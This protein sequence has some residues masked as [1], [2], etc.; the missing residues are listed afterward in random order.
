MSAQLTGPGA[1]PRKSE[2]TLNKIKQRLSAIGLL[3]V[4][5]SFPPVASFAFHQTKLQGKKAIKTHLGYRI[6]VSDNVVEESW[7]ESWAYIIIEQCD[8]EPPVMIRDEG[9]LVTASDKKSRS[10]PRSASSLLSKAQRLCPPYCFLQTEPPANP[11]NK[12]CALILYYAL[13]NGLADTATRWNAFENSLIDAI[14]YIEQRAEYQQ[15]RSEQNNNIT[16]IYQDGT[17]SATSEAAR[18]NVSDGSQTPGGVVR[19]VGSAVSI[20]AGT[21]L[22]KLKDALGDERM[23]LLDYIPPY[24]VTIERHDID[25]YWPFRLQLGTYGDSN[26]YVYMK[27][28]PGRTDCKIMSHGS[29]GKMLK[30]WSFADLRGLQLSEPFA[31]F[32]KIKQDLATRG[33]KVLYLAYY[34][35]MLAENEGIIDSPRLQVTTS[36]MVPT[37]VAACRNLA[38]AGNDR[39]ELDKAQ[40]Q[41]QANKGN[42]V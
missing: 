27:H 7:A 4:L 19:P 40:R 9:S 30:W 32:M 36:T 41:P 37:F 3:Q 38:E 42:K 5:E 26:V 25:D 23:H 2:P 24:P 14:A 11:R 15:W 33:N 8:T 39:N 16:D 22:E 34:Y 6:Q 20:K 31:C 13:V 21:T 10:Y 35:L 29:D 18:S 17:L 12:L 1:I 28:G